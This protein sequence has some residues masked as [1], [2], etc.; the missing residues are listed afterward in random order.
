MFRTKV[1]DRREPHTVYPTLSI[2][3][4]N[5]CGFRNN[6]QTQPE[7][8]KLHVR[9]CNQVDLKTQTGAGARVRVA[10]KRWLR[11][12]VEQASSAFINGSLTILTEK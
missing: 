8:L 7:A 11:R 5:S 3:R 10:V 4:T 9:I 2:Q 1:V 12:E 6:E